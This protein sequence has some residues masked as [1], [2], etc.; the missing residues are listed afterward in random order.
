MMVLNAVIL[1]LPDLTQFF[2][3]LSTSNLTA[4]CT[5]RPPDQPRK[6]EINV[7]V[8]N[9]R[10]QNLDIHLSFL[11]N[12]Y[13]ESVLIP[14]NW[15]ITKSL[16]NM[17]KLVMERRGS[18]VCHQR[19]ETLIRSLYGHQRPIADHLAGPGTDFIY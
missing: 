9:H 13:S 3:S 15:L 2:S 16:G 4:N 11:L 14:G 5:G 7:F 19:R 10:S 17:N 18:I 8:I 1:E 12:V 6:W